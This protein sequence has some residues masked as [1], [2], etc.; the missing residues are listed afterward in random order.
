MR[1]S[2]KHKGDKSPQ[3]DQPPLHQV[4]MLAVLIPMLM[5]AGPAVGFLL[6]RW[7]D[8]KLGWDPWGQLGGLILGLAAGF[9]ESYLIVK[10]LWK[11]QQ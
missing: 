5:L 4:A 9:R 1:R 7:L 3:G 8:S 10:R 6:G 2:D 11:L